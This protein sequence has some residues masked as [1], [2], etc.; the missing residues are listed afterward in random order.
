MDYQPGHP[1]SF[2]SAIWMGELAL[3]RLLRD[4]EGALA[5]LKAMALPYPEKLREALALPVGG[6]VQHRERADGYPQ[7]RSELHRR[8]CVQVTRLRR[9]SPFRPQPEL[10]HQ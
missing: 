5:Q 3:C 10:S 6:S 8:M 4:P 9:P 2:C 1:H 7:G